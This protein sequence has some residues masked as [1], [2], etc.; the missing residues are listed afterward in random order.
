MS[1]SLV[2]AAARARRRL[3][4]HL[5]GPARHVTP[6][7]KSLRCRDGHS[8][9]WNDHP[10][11]A[12][13][14]VAPGWRQRCVLVV[15]VAAALVG[16][17]GAVLQGRRSPTAF[18]DWAARPLFEHIGEHGRVV[19]LAFSAQAMTIGA[20]ALIAVVAAL[21]RRW[22]VVAL[23]VTGPILAVV[24]TE[25]VLKPMVDSRI[26]GGPQGYAYPS[27]H[28][29][30]LASLILVILLLVP[31]APL[32]R[33]MRA[34]VVVLL[35]LWAALGA[36]GLVRAHYHFPLDTLGGIGVAIVCVLTGALV[37]DACSDRL[38]RPARAE[39]GA[40]Q[41]T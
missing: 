25:Y 29:T 36:L 20:L 8:Y 22:E 35:T 23:A 11:P 6:S 27:G 32:S 16:V 18:D 7:R 38:R 14:F 28:E 10:M 41:F 30:G 15:V 24:M 26:A 1:F 4:A 17:L 34:T 3:V 12:P 31:C 19:L 21:A 37:V 5:P 2:I 33:P 39:A 9:V 40:G 13:P